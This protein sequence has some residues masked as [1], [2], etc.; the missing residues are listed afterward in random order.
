MAASRLQGLKW[1][2]L[3]YS[4]QLC[5][6]SPSLKS[7]SESRSSGANHATTM[8]IPIVCHL[9]V[10]AADKSR[11]LYVRSIAGGIHLMVAAL[12]RWADAQ[13][14]KWQAMTN[15]LQGSGPTKVGFQFWWGERRDLLDGD[16][17]YKPI[18][19][20][21]RGLSS[22]PDFLFRRAEF[23]RGH[24]GDHGFRSSA[25]R[26]ATL[27]RMSSACSVWG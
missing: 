23:S 12:L 14:S 2:Q 27:T 26:P 17:W 10:I 9:A 15:C 7:F 25:L 16:S 13:R 8:P 22:T 18:Q 24:A 6:D 20:S 1:A 11:S 19:Q 3:N 5:A 4:L 21:Y